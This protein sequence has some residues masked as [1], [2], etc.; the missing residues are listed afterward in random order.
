MNQ[1][2]GFVHYVKKVFDLSC[3]AKAVTDRRPWPQ[4]P[5][6]C[7]WLSLFF[8][9]VMRVPS[10]LQLEAETRRRCWQRWIQWKGPIS[11]DT[12]GYVAEQMSLDDLRHT[13]L[14]TNKIL[15]ANKAFEGNKINGLLIAAVDGNEQF[16]SQSRCCESCLQRQRH[17]KDA[18][19]QEY[20]VTEY[21]HKQ[22]YCQLIGPHL[23]VILDL[24]PMRSGEDE[25]AATL[26]LLG[27]VRR[28]YGVRF[29]DVLGVDAGFIEG[30]FLTAVERL[31]WAVISVLKQQRYEIWQE[32]ENLTRS[33]PPTQKLI[34]EQREVQLWEVKDLP[35]TETYR[36]HIRVVRSEEQW[37]QIKR[38]GLKR[39]EMKMHQHWRWVATRGL[40]GYEPKVIWQIGH[41]R[42][43][44][45]NNA[46]NELTQHW[47]LEHCAHHHPKAII[48]LLLIKVL[49]FNLF[50]AFAQLHVKLWRI[51]KITFQEL[52]LQLYRALE[53]EPVILFFSG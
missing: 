4:I 23:N 30:P 7:V 31:G 1:L 11:D 27:R 21:Y 42:W 16:C 43:K 10:F 18:Q 46:F 2:Q 12:F 5:T 40:D 15:K 33:K 22:V 17:C 50:K 45:E 13:L 53:R 26:R 52:R 29:F 3:L 47:N 37:T 41:L 39:I 34:Q 9:A 6:S 51:G 20:E 24:E 38:K 8:G 28:L 44:I 35:F 25:I 36:G 14:Q 48:V 19:G 32:S 49:A